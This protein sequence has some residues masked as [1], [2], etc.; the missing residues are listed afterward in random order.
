MSRPSVRWSVSKLR[1]SGS[2]SS[3]VDMD[4]SHVAMTPPIQTG[5]ADLP[6]PAFRSVVSTMDWLRLGMKGLE[7]IRPAAR[8][9][10]PLT[11]FTAV[12]NRAFDPPKAFSAP[13]RIAFWALGRFDLFV[14]SLILFYLPT[15]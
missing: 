5:R 10:A 9:C 11:A 15:S 1:V 8:A 12:H 6:H 2:P 7:V 3:S 14:G 4:R 13:A